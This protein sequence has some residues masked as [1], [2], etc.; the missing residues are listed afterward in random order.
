M[1]G[2]R[3][4]KRIRLPPGANFQASVAPTRTRADN[5]KV[6]VTAVVHG[7]D[8]S[9]KARFPYSALRKRI[10]GYAPTGEWYGIAQCLENQIS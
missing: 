7:D 10:S 2:P 6:V 4:I 9:A 8:W 1:N 5:N 3:S